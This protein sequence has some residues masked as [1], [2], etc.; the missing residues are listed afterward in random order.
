MRD[1]LPDEMR[2][3]SA[4]LTVIINTYEK[5]GFTQI[6]TPA[7]EELSLLLKDT[8]SENTK[9]IFSI[10]KRGEELK[11]AFDMQIALSDLGLRYDLTVPLARYFSLNHSK[12]PSVFKSI[13]IG[14]VWRAERPQKGRFRQF[15]QCDIDIIGETSFWS[16]LELINA[17][18]KALLNL[19][20][21]AFIIQIN[22]RRLLSALMSFCGFPED[23]LTNILISLDKL[24]KIGIEGVKKEL[25]EYPVDQRSIE[26][27]IK[28]ITTNYDADNNSLKELQETLYPHIEPQVIDEL[29]ILIEQINSA[30]DALYKC[31]FNPTLVRGMGYYTGPI[32]EITYKNYPFSIA[33]GGRYDKMIGQL[34]NKEVPACGI[35]LG[36]ERLI[37]ILT[38]E[39]LLKLPQL[40]TIA[41]LYDK[42]IEPKILASTINSI[43]KSNQYITI[44]KKQKNFSKQLNNLLTNGISR[45]M[46]V[47]MDN[48]ISAIKEIKEI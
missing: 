15:Y 31:I 44:Y 36:F 7:V 24:D 37:G 22:D 29:C 47:N 16:E 19:G 46:V 32:F 34:A 4:A 2:L 42:E 45:Y 14:P 38:E 28:V 40:E 21:N 25:H 11:K 9:L 41:L 6:E 43:R 8:G 27:L 26:Q 23:Q 30:S 17:S 3:R 39:Q 33:G 12:L 10:L 35:S 48:T 5:F 1:I 18:S 20:I 13:Q